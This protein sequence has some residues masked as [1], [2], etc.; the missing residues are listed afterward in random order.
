MSHKFDAPAISYELKNI[1]N[2]IQAHATAMANEH[3]HGQ[4]HRQGHARGHGLGHGIVNGHGH[5]HGH[6]HEH[7]QGSVTSMGIGN[8]INKY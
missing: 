2:V 6:C 5:G 7:G 1:Y 3:G 8:S 4:V